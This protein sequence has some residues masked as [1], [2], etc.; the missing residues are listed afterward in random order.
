M[1]PGPITPTFQ[2]MLRVVAW[3]MSNSERLPGSPCMRADAVPAAEPPKARKPTPKRPKVRL[4]AEASCA[5]PATPPRGVL[6]LING[7]AA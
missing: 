4:V 7:G 5:P 6:R 3:M 2:D 1:I